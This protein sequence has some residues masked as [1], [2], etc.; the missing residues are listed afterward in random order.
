VCLCEW[1]SGCLYVCVFLCEWVFVG[2]CLCEWVRGCLCVCVCVGVFVYVC[3]M[4]YVIRM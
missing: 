4:T 3:A 1:V 2:V